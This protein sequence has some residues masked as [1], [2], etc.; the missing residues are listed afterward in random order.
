MSSRSYCRSHLVMNLRSALDGE[1]NAHPAADAQ[2]RQA[3]L[4]VALL[5]L[6]QQRH[7]DAGARSTDRMTDGDGTPV[8]IHD[9][10]IPSHVLVD[11]DRLCGERFVRFDKIE[12][13]DLPARFFERPARGRDRSRAHD[14][15]STPAVTHDAMRASGVTPRRLASDAFMTTNAAAPSL[16]PDALPAVT[17]PSLEKAGLSWDTASSVVPGRICSSRSITISPLRDGTVT[18]AISSLKRPD[19]WAASALFW[20]ATANLSCSSRLICHF[21]ATFSAVVPM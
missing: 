8:D 4:G 7:K 1:R 3:A 13:R 21:C 11:R 18:G 2:R 5:H 17:V 12:I 15:R 9:T 19:F 16:R 14:F 20:E 6:V 10:G